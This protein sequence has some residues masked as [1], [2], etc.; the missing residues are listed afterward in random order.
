MWLLRCT[1]TGSLCVKERGAGGLH[2]PARGLRVLMPVACYQP[3]NPEVPF[4][5]TT[6][7]LQGIFHPDVPA[8]FKLKGHLETF[9]RVPRITSLHNQTPSQSRCASNSVHRL[10]FLQTPQRHPESRQSNDTAGLTCK[11]GMNK[12]CSVTKS[13]VKRHQGTNLAGPF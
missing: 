9:P 7:N 10:L 5:T 4:T 11:I 8:E 1:S 13:N 2:E 3:G 6:R 12:I